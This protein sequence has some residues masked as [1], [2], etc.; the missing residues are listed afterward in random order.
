ML[1]VN[2][3]I[4]TTELNCNNIPLTTHDTLYNVHGNVFP[5]TFR[6]QYFTEFIIK[7][8]NPSYMSDVIVPKKNDVSSKGII[9]GKL[10]HDAKKT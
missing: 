1:K 3:E 9:S 7:L 6:H 4:Q 5:M 10:N 2:R 8:S